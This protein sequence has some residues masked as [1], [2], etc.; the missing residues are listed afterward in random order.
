MDFG[1]PFSIEMVFKVYEAIEDQT[2]FDL[3]NDNGA[4]FHSTWLWIHISLSTLYAT[5]DTV[6][7]AF[8]MLSNDISLLI[9]PVSVDTF[10]LVLGFDDDPNNPG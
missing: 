3:Y 4:G 9:G 10:V 2:L 8:M 1:L 5:Y 7:D 6:D